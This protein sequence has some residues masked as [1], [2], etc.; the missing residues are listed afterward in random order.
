MK[1]IKPAPGKLFCEPEV[2][3]KT[4][5]AGIILTQQDKL[6]PK[7]AKVINCGEGCTYSRDDRIVYKDYAASE[8]ELNDTKYFIIDE[9]DIE[10]LLVEVNEA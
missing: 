6:E 2:K 3:D 9:K 10:G 5:A 8:L 7:F 4:T 1:T